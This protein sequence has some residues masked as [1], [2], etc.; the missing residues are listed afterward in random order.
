M[1]SPD[2]APFRLSLFNLITPP[3]LFVASI[4]HAASVMRIRADRAPYPHQ[5][6]TL[7]RVAESSGGLNAS[8]HAT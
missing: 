7:I 5:R 3:F 2:C 6:S 1:G 8:G 4:F